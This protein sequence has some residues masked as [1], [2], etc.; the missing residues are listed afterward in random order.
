MRQLGSE[1]LMSLQRENKWLIPLLV[2]GLL[3]WLAGVLVARGALLSA[4][5]RAAKPPLV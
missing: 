5:L 4:F 1:A 2:V 3:I